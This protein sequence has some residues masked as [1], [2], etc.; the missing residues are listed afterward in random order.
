MRRGGIIILAILFTVLTGRIG[1]QDLQTV[2]NNNR[3]ALKLDAR[4]NIKN[5]H[6]SG[7]FIMSGSDAKIPFQV[8]QAKPDL[9]RIETTVFGFKAIQTYDG[10]TAWTLSP[11]QGMEALKTETRDMEFIAAA[12]ALDGPFSLNKEGKYTLKY[13]G[14]DSYQDRPVEIL[15]LTSE[16]ERLKYYINRE[17]WL[18]EGIRYEYNKNGGWYSMEYRIK[19]YQEFMGTLFPGEIAA[20]I[21]G[22]EM[23]SLFVTNIKTLE[24]LDMK[25]FGKPSFNM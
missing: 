20:V 16:T 14:A 25:R 5:L 18:V 9:L 17:N 6:S 3:A 1:A 15:T 10:T 8:T 4:K 7:H 24:N 21:N 13:S 23:L 12:T 19:S 2:L 11:M 22:V